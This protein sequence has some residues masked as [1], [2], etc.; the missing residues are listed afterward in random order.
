M[1]DAWP[2]AQNRLTDRLNELRFLRQIDL[3]RICSD[4]HW[5]F[6]RFA[7]L[8]GR[9]PAA[10][11]PQGG[12]DPVGESFKAL[13]RGILGVIPPYL[14]PLP[15]HPQTRPGLLPSMSLADRAPVPNDSRTPAALQ[16]KLGQPT[17]HRSSTEDFCD[18]LSW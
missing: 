14:S 16:E 6:L 3:M 8:D 13:R 4:D 15:D 12:T 11:W 18:R 1:I 10:L 9:P 17:F 5:L 7:Q 2:A